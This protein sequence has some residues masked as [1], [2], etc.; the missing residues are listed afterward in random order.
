VVG[1][2]VAGTNNHE[3]RRPF[4]DADNDVVKGA[5]GCKKKNR[6]FKQFQIDPHHAD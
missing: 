3:N 5:G 6:F 4:G 1:Q 2:D